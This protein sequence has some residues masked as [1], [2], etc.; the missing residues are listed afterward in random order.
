MRVLLVSPHP[1]DVAWSIG[2]IVERLGAFAD[3]TVCTVFGETRWAPGSNV[4]GSPV[5]GKLRES[6][7]RAWARRVGARI[8]WLRHP[9]ASLRG[10]DD[11]SELGGLPEPVLVAQIAHGLT[12]LTAALEPALVLAPRAIGAHVDHETVRL[13]VDDIR[14]R[15]PLATAWYEDLP[16]TAGRETPPL[17]MPFTVDVTA[18]WA[19]KETAARLHASQ[20]PDEVL[21]DIRAHALTV[22]GGSLRLAERLWVTDHVTH[23]RLSGLE[24]DGQFQYFLGGAEAGPDVQ[25]RTPF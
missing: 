10:Y 19:A 23:D 15:V 16:Y 24:L 14:R 21:P 1:D 18:Q 2:G 22:G 8:E 25:G 11:D 13:A 7:D 17:G 4:H 3:L 20:L 6:E 12:A 5:A 9:D